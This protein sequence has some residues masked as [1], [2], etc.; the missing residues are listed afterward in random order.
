MIIGLIVLGWIICGVLAYGMTLY[1]FT[2]MFP[3]LNHKGIARWMGICG[4]IGILVC[5]RNVEHKGFMWRARS[6]QE[7]WE[8]YQG[9]Y[10]YP[11]TLEEFKR[12]YP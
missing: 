2:E 12:L 1:N 6:L 11:G 5:F 3:Y 4:P 9:T 7:R 8:I 10:Q